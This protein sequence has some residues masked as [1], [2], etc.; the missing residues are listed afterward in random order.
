M[1]RLMHEA[2]QLEPL[3]A[4]VARPDCGAVAT[5]LGVTR[6]RHEGRRVVALAYEAYER[7]ALERLDAIEREAAERFAIAR[8]LIVHRLGSV[9]VGEASVAVVVAAP[10]R[11]PAF[12]ACRWT[13][14]ELKA[15]VP[16][17]KKESYA[18][19]DAAWASG[20]PLRE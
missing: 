14:D 2:I 19:G 13:M 11:G 4:E 16:I 17:W 5:F 6:D 15:T 12:D 20:T 9:P 1:A 3:V 10:H 7:M 8:C 18:E